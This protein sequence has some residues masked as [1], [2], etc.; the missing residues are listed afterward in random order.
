[1]GEM[2]ETLVTV[3][4]VFVGVWTLGFAF[5][6]GATAAVMLAL[7]NKTITLRTSAQ[8]SHQAEETPNG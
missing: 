7:R 5:G 1:M 8:P 6:W 2:I 4:L 3:C